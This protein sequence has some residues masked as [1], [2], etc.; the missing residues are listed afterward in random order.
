MTWTDH[1]WMTARRTRDWLHQP[2][3]DLRS[4]PGLV[5]ARRPRAS[6][7]TTARWRTS[8]STTSSRS[9]F[10]HIEL[11]PVTEH[12]LDDSWGY[13]TTG[14][15][16]PTSR[17]G[18]PDDFRYFVDHC[19]RNGIGVLLDWAPGALPQGRATRWPASTAPPCTNTPTRAAA[20]TATGAR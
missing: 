1:D 20:N 17:F 8:W 9:G 16:A 7:S 13:Q 12:P 2:H 15:F 18:T 14:Y 5:A 3:V 6:S 11:L 4:P 19:H 10:T